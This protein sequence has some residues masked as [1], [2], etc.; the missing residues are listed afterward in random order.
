M[1]STPGIGFTSRH[2]GRKAGA[3]MNLQSV[4]T[5]APQTG[6][7]CT[8]NGSANSHLNSQRTHLLYR[9]DP[10]EELS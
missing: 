5:K 1:N 10:F 9:V 8:T 3:G 2:S 4:L 7:L 6:P